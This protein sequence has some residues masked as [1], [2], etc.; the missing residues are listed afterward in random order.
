[1]QFITNYIYLYHTNK[2]VIIP[3]YP[4]SFTD[5]MS[6]TF[7]QT[8]A[9]S[10]SAPVFSYAYSGPRQV[11]ISLNL[12]RDMV[13]DLNLTAGNT[14][15]KSNVMS[16]TDD[17]VDDLIKELQSIALPRYNANN[18]AVIPPR[19]AVRF[20]NDL[21]ITGVVSSGIQCTYE[22]PI[23]TNGK[24]AKVTITFN[25]FEYDPY[26]AQTVATE[27][28]FRGITSTNNIISSGGGIWTR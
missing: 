9:L 15:L 10:R 4:D 13:N 16:Q 27:G 1:M 11:T 7:N 20:G 6:T 23:L 18:K 12:H 25:V 24:Y 28:S 14:N 8:N 26:D 3:E 17:Y 21:F 5:S 22:K 19:I 2:F